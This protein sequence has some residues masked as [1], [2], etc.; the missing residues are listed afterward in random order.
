L[1]SAHTE[2]GDRE[3]QR[4][5]GVDPDLLERMHRQLAGV[6]DVAER[7]MVGG[8]SFMVGGHLCCGVI[9]NALMVRVG[10]ASCDS[11]L[12][13]PHVRPLLIGGKAPPGYVC[14]D[15]VGWGTDGELCGCIRAGIAFVS[16]LC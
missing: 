12:A 1:T 8:R 5:V 7:R 15:P 16:S 11:A 4:H 2:P 14:V 13:R 6:P 10:P 9:G 3:H